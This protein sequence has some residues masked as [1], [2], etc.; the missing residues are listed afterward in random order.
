MEYINNLPNYAY[1][2]PFIVVRVCDGEFWFWGAYK[3][4]HRAFEVASEIDGTVV[5]NTKM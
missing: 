4:N 5:Y 3:T 2:Y 1:E